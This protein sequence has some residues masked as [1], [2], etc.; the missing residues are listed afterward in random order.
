MSM[1]PFAP[2]ALKPLKGAVKY[3]RIYA[4]VRQVPV[5]QVTTYGNIARLVPGCTPRMVGYAMAALPEGMDVPWH[6]VINAQGRI[7]IRRDGDDGLIQRLLLEAEGVVFDRD[8]RT[9]LECYGWMVPDLDF[10]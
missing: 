1:I 5:G 2:Q 6:R 7:S 3:Q 10:L 9:A 8:G 4:L